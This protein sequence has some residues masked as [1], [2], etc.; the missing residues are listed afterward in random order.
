MKTEEAKADEGEGEKKTNSFLDKT[1]QVIARTRSNSS[2][3][4]HAQAVYKKS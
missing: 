1:D 3:I 2:I 4:M